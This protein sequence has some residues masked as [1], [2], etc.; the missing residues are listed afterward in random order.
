M[1]TKLIAIGN[2]KGIRIPKAAIEQYGLRDDIELDLRADSLV[3]RPVRAPRKGWDDAFA[4][5]RR[6]GDDQIVADVDN[7]TEF[8]RKEWTW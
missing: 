2:S 4:R 6:R 5:M 8:G 1:R 7:T 3:I